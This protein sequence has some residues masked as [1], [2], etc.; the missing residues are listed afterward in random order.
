MVE[1]T[2]DSTQEPCNQSPRTKHGVEAKQAGKWSQKPLLETLL[3]SGDFSPWVKPITLPAGKALE[4]AEVFPFP[5]PHTWGLQSSA[6][7]GERLG[8]GCCS[9]ASLRGLL[10]FVLL[11]LHL[12]TY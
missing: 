11:C 7:A 12:A 8:R 9:M 3:T 1:T 10:G 6:T 5:L 2:A 4:M